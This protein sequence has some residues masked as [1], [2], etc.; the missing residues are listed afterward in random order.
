MDR[1]LKMGLVGC[2]GISQIA[3]LPAL[4][5]ADN[6]ELIAACDVAQD[7]V[8]MAARRYYIPEVYTDLR[9]M[10]ERSDI[11]AVLVTA[12]HAFHAE[13]SIECMRAGKHVLCEKPLAMS[14][15]ECERIVEVSQETGMQLQLACMKRYDPGLQFAQRFVAE[16]MGERLA[17]SG[18]YCDTVFH[19]QYVRSL[20]PMR[21]S[22]PSQKRPERGTGDR[23]LDILLGHGVHAVDTIRFFGGEIVSVSSGT[24]RKGGDI[25][26]V[27]LLEFED[28]SC[29]TLQLVCTVKMDWFEGVFVHGQYG[30]VTAQIFFPYYRRGSDVKVFDA[31]RGEYRTPATPDADP[32]ERQLE[33]FADAILNDKPVSPNAYDGLMDQKVLE[34]IYEASRSGGRV[35]IEL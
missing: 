20:V 6:V 22:S 4:K 29:G 18:W 3:H 26:S 31:R 34:A 35:P 7:L 24:T 5:K 21:A 19:G 16:E 30:S 25:A 23:L 14:V 28:G 13:I 32:Y 15:E 1:K 12:H 11:D 10:L 8:E 33:A 17:I 2:G 9:E 27:S